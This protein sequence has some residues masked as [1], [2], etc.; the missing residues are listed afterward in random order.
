MTQ[1]GLLN[2]D[3]ESP[4]SVDGV[5]SQRWNSKNPLPTKD[6]MV[7]VYKMFIRGMTSKNFGLQKHNFCFE[8]DH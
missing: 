4:K 3:G 6:T 8:K 7:L 5:R 2:S 1:T